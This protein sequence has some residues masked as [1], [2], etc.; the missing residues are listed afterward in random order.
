M[1][2]MSPAPA[3]PEIRWSK[4]SE[5]I[6]IHGLRELARAVD[7]EVPDLQQ[8]ALGRRSIGDKL[9]SHIERRLD[10]PYGWLSDQDKLCC[11]VRT[12]TRALP[13]ADQDLILAFVESRF[14]KAAE[15]SMDASTVSLLQAMLDRAKKDREK[16]RLAR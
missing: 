11:V 5:L 13:P 6:S 2:E 3:M 10:L 4:L 7:R 9:S 15:R 14:K 1:D 12:I 8:Y 16:E